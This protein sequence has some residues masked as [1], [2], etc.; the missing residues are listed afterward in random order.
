MQALLRRTRTHEQDESSESIAA[1]GGV[2]A[3]QLRVAEQYVEQFGNL[4]RSSTT[5]VLPANLSDVGSMIALATSVL[6]G[7][8]ASWAPVPA[9]P[10]T[11]RPPRP[12]PLP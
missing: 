7:T 2:E 5:L 4:A 8:P 6:R 10:T 11:A 12:P 9:A 3:V 1:P